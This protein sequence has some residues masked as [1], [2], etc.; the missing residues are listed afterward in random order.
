[1]AVITVPAGFSVA[2]QTWEQARLD[3]NFTSIFGAQAV[4]VGSPL[5]STTI[6]SSLKR[7]ELWQAVMMKLRGRTN[8]LELWN[9]GRPIPKGTMRGAMTA[10]A[11]SMGAT[12]M[13]I[14]AAGQASKTLLTG[15]YLGVGSGVT[16]QVVMLIADATS[17][18]SGVITVIFE[19][20]LRNA[21]S[22][23][24]VVTWDRPKAL[25]RR[26]D[27]KVGW[28]YEPGV[29]KEMSMILLE[30]WRA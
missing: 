15:D 9:F 25:F 12:A 24:A 4:E 28:D 10:S 26:A 5:W 13:T 6:T 11:A 14:S 1:M 2:K 23:G 27:P 21:V 20:A 19:P 7:P 17:N 22:G 29:V 18:G 16:Q 30:D 3:M 8:Q